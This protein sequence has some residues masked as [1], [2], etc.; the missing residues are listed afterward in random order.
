MQPL[1]GFR[2]IHHPD[3]AMYSAIEHTL[4]QISEAFGYTEIRLPILEQIDLFKRSVGE[5]T[6]IIGKE[7]YHFSDQNE[8]VIALRPEGTASATRAMI[9]AGLVGRGSAKWWYCG[10]M[11]RRERPQK[12][13]YRQFTQFGIEFYGQDNISADLELIML[14]W[15]ALGA[16]KLSEHVKLHINFLPKAAARKAYIIDL[17]SYLKTQE[18][19]LPADVVQRAIDNPLRVLDSK[20]PAVIECLTAA[21]KLSDYL[22]DDEKTQIQMVSDVLSASGIEFSWDPLL[23]RGLD[24]YAGIVF[25]WQSTTLGAQS[26]VC[27]GGRYDQLT[28]QLDA[29]PWPATGLSFGIDRLTLMCQTLG[30][31]FP[32]KTRIALIIDGM[33][34]SDAFTIQK[35]WQ[36]HFDLHAHLDHSTSSPKKAIQRAQKQGHRYVLILREDHYVIKDLE[37]FTEA[38]LNI[39]QSL[40]P[41]IQHFFQKET[42]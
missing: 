17:Q 3:A 7:M 34:L 22:A 19:K 29:K 25:E 12:G 42:S 8:Q 6:D 5:H 1:R 32:S 40:A 11:F 21:P 13:R 27:G 36:S 38:K 39:T 15:Q 16:L 31:Q 4:I 9:N 26:A 30:V 24:Y 35:Q 2:D 41:T 20:D 28:A 33:N 18:S 23:V 14:S 37:A 10:P